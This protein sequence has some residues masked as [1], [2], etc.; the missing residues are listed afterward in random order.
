[1][2]EGKKDNDA[3]TDIM[4]EEVERILEWWTNRNGTIKVKQPAWESLCMR[5]SRQATASCRA[6]HC[7]A[8]S[9]YSRQAGA[10]TLNPRCCLTLS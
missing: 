1:M 2:E 9:E 6:F 8:E 3:Q 5:V 10:N 4:K 7:E